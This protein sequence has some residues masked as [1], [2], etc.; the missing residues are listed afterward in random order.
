LPPGLIS[1]QTHDA[2]LDLFGSFFAP[3]CI[4]IDMDQFKQGMHRCLT[5]SPDTPALYR[6]TH[7]SPLLHNALLSLA[8]TLWKGGQVQPFPFPASTQYPTHLPPAQVASNALY[9]QA[10][11][12]MEGEMTRPIVSTVRAMMLIASINASR[13]RAT[14]GYTYAGMAFRM[15]SVLGL[16][17][18]CGRYVDKGIITPDVRQSRDM[19]FHTAFVQE[20]VS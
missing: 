1:R 19:V 7:Y 8:C 20:R 14:L 15:C 18:D 2:L 17:I 5:S 13:S 3:W 11:V 12:L 4:V 9:D 16:N 10:K 6:S